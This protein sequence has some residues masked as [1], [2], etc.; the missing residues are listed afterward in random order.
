MEGLLLWLDNIN[1]PPA[2]PG[3]FR[4]VGPSKRGGL[5]AIQIQDIPDLLRLRHVQLDNLWGGKYSGKRQTSTAP[6]G[7]AGGALWF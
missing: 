5:I 3:G 6:P 4:I 1:H 7:K 2:R